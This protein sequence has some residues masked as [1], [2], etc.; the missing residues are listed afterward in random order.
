[1]ASGGA[2]GRLAAGA[3][4]LALAAGFAGF[5]GFAGC[6]QSRPAVHRGN[7]VVVVIDTLRRDHLAT[8]GYSR[9]PA[10]FLGELAR[11]GAAFDGITPA[12]WTK[13]ATASLLTGLHPV[14]HQAID[15]VDSLPAAA[16]TLAERLRSEGYQTLGASANGWVSPAFGFTRGFDDFL[17]RD[18]VKAA[19]LNRDLL[20]K[21]DRLKPPFFL[22]VHYIDPHI[23][24][25]P[26]IGWDG[27]PLPA[28]LR[29]HPVTIEEIDAPHFVQRS[30]QLL[31]RARDSYDGE[32][33]QADEGLRQLVGR[34][35]QRGLMK[36]TVLV[37]TADHGEELGD[38]GRMSHGQTVYQ[39]ILRVPLVI[40]APGAV[41]AGLHPGRASLM[42]VVPTLLELLGVRQ[43][44]GDG[45]LDGVSLAGRFAGEPRAADRP[46]LAQLDF[47]DGTALALTQGR[48]KVVLQKNPYRKELFDLDADPGERANLLGRPGDGTVF[49]RLTGELAD[50][51]NGYSRKR[52]QRDDAQLGSELVRSLADLGYLSAGQSLPRRGVPRRIGPADP[53]PNG[54][55]GW[56]GAGAVTSCAQIGKKK[57]GDLSLLAGWYEPD[58]TGRWSAQRSSVVLAIP[59]GQTR[60]E[61]LV[62]GNN[63]RPAPV[64]VTLSVNRHPVLEAELPGGPFRLSAPLTGAPLDDPAL[65][66]VTTDSA[67]VPARH[68]LADNRS[69]GLYL[70]AICLEPGAATGG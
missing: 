27:K 39:E 29:S 19:A 51:Y 7:V 32:I 15:R 61:L 69:L 24:Y 26:D 63:F 56:A 5:A 45:A 3:L 66:E 49:T 59:T 44:R 31:A 70:T 16:L 57:D 21:L 33:R 41:P 40:R 1:M 2:A 54:R 64:R 55:L 53:F 30:P 12:P 13:P 50:L 10:P 42:D 36:N 43:P 34:L 60:P 65:V 52:L 20:P 23:P 47:V 22:Y 25:D 68:G 11:Q 9:D 62:S 38:H 46:F 37:V 67:F 14:H 6:R 8:Y 48:Y 18:N 35:A 17:F 58:G 4:L 28:A